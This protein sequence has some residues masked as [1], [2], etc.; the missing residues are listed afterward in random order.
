MTS[1]PRFSSDKPL[2]LSPLQEFSG[3]LK[4]IKRLVGRDDTV[5]PPRIWETAQ[6]DFIEVGVIR[7]SEPYPWPTAS[8]FVRYTSPLTDRD[9]QNR[10]A[11]LCNS[12]RQFT[13]DIYDLVGKQ[14][15]WAFNPATI[16]GQLTDEEGNAILE[17]E[18]RRAGKDKWGEVTKDC[19]LVTE[20]VGLSKESGGDVLDYIA[21]ML[22][23]K[24]E[25]DFYS[26][27]LQDAKVRNHPQII[28]QIT[29]RELLEVLKS[30]GVAHR[31]EDGVWHKGPEPTAI[32]GGVA[33]A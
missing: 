22:D 28:E 6:F 15:T 25:A 12:V 24:L 20:V 21:D 3:T 5:S 26:A 27:A 8:I 9:G 1:E 13:P 16:R 7:A 29:K 33:G 30:T 14:Q 17:T 2:G 4:E 32:T 10:W 19:W 11:V 23:G 18:G 31:T